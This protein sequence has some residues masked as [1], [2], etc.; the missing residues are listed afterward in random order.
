MMKTSLNSKLRLYA[1]EK[2]RYLSENLKLKD[3]EVFDFDKDMFQILLNILNDHENIYIKFEILEI[4]VNFTNISPNFCEL[5]LDVE[6]FM[7]IYKFLD[8]TN[9]M[10]V[11][12]GLTIIGNIITNL[13]SSYEYIIKYFP[14]EI[15]LK[16][17]M[18]SGKFD[19]DK[20]VLS[21]ILWILRAVVKQ[22]NKESYE[23]VFQ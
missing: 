20:P 18:L 23:M 5:L 8:S 6:Y 19:N 9:N 14:L 11:E 2:L 4:L 22:I 7:I 17:H 3:N 15:K 13:K 12:K 21:N 1:L 10:F 16:E